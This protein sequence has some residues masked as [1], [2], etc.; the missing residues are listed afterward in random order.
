M[1]EDLTQRL[2][3]KED[4]FT[5]RKPE[6]AGTAD[7]KKTLVSFANSVPEDGTAVLFIGVSDDI[8]KSR[9]V[10]NPDSLQKKIRGICEKDCYPPIKFQCQVIPYEDKNLLAVIIPFSSNR[11]HFAGPAYIRLGSES[12]V[13]SEEIFQQ[14]IDS[15]TS[16]VAK[17]IQWRG[18]IVTVEAH[19]KVLGNTR[20]IDER[21]RGGIR[22]KHECEVLECNNHYV[23]MKDIS[24][25]NQ[26]SEPLSNVKVNYDVERDRL[27][28]VVSPEV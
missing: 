27:M 5:E 24:S 16:R 23:R 1:N 22:K 25:G 2:L 10:S 14:L 8:E 11:P 4:G 21:Y 17:I 20:Y 15:R 26:L 18:K 7:F 19:G 28:L 3:N 6:G 13:A 9:G 12:V